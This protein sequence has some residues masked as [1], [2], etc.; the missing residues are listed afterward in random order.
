M[1]ERWGEEGRRERGGKGRDF[2]IRLN[3]G[4]RKNGGRMRRGREG[5]GSMKKNE[6]SK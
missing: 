6:Q 1:R 2:Y 3:E 4:E 5:R